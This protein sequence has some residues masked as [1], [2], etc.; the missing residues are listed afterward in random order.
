HLA[1]DLTAERDDEIGDAVEPLP[2]PGIEFGRLVVARRR[3]I[4]LVVAAGKT[5]CEPFLALAAESG[6]PVGRRPA[7]RPKLVSQ[8][9]RLGEMDRT[10]PPRLFP[11][12][13]QRRLAKILAL[14]DAALRHLPFES[15][16]DDLG[17]I[18]AEAAA[19]QHAAFRIEQRNADIGTIGF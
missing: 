3:R 5:Q 4:D 16:Q 6:E 12:F 14:V 10:P 13:A 17:T 9:I 11:E 2:A 8:P 1:I 19:D 7:V 18:A 15:R